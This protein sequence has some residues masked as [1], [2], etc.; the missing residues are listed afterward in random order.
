M[1][2]CLQCSINVAVTLGK[3]CPDAP[4]ESSVHYGKGRDRNSTMVSDEPAMR[5]HL[6]AE[7]E[8]KPRGWLY[9]VIRR[10]VFT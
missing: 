10:V 8:T 4:T 7:G 9:G 2:P 6:E 1:M 5:D 3:R